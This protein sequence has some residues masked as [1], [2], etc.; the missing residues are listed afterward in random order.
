MAFTSTV[1]RLS[2]E[3]RGVLEKNVRAAKTER[4]ILAQLDEALPEGE[5]VWTAGCLRRRSA[6]S[7]RTTS[8]GSL[9]NT[10]STCSG[11][12]AGA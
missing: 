4:R 9:A 10:A 2:A 12:A 8:G 5:T 7:P 3:E 11:A 6:T 1:I